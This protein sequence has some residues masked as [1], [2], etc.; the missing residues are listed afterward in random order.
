MP[1]H[2][3]QSITY[4]PS[5]SLILHGR[6]GLLNKWVSWKWHQTIWGWGSSNTG[7]LGNTRSLQS[8]PCPLR[9]GVL[10]P[11]RFQSMGQIEL[12][13]VLIQNRI[14]WNKLSIC[15]I[16]DLAL[17]NLQW[18]VCH[19]IKADTVTRVQTLDETDYI[20]HSSNTLGKGMNP[21]I[22]PPAMGK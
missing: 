10:K 5:L 22:L 17:N 19:K 3:N 20:S 4:P 2:W 14:V 6:L 15:I 7:A 12:N 21:I 11:H 8:L 13:C 18:L 9:L 16:I 1:C